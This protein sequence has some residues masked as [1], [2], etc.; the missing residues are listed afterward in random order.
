MADAFSRY[1]GLNCSVELL[2]LA[3]DYGMSINLFT[4]LTSI[5]AAEKNVPLLKATQSILVS[6]HFSRGFGKF[7]NSYSN[8]EKLMLFSPLDCV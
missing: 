8:Y 4:L 7:P 6:G 3:K 2:T 1:F 5:D